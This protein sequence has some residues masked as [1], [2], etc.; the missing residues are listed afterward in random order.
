MQ[1][2]QYLT[3]PTNHIVYNPPSTDGQGR[4]VKACCLSISE[5]YSKW[6]LPP[7]P[8]CISPALDMMGAPPRFKQ[9][10]GNYGMKRTSSKA[11]FQI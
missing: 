9:R 3:K 5:V 4:I 2:K 10:A 7:T 6:D 11:G 1:D 8:G